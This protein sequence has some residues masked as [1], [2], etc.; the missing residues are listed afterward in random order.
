MQAP[1]CHVAIQQL[2]PLIPRRALGVWGAAPAFF[3][4]PL[5]VDAAT[6]LRLAKRHDALALRWGRLRVCLEQQLC[7]ALVCTCL[8]VEVVQ[9]VMSMFW[10]G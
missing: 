1:C 5:V 8:W 6:G 7:A 10:W 3:H 4:C 2:L 9:A